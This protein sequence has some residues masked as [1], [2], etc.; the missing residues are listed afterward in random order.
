MP[1]DTKLEG[2]PESIRAVADWL[3]TSLQSNVE[4]AATQIFNARNAAGSG[5]SGS[6][7]EAFRQRMTRGGRKADDLA[8]GIDDMAQKFD[9]HA[10]KL[11]QAQEAMEGA[12]GIARSGG[13][14]IH[15]EV[16][17]DAGPAPAS[18]T[19]LPGD[20]SAT[21]EMVHART[22]AVDA[23]NSHARKVDAYRAATAEV[24][25][26]RSLQKVW[27]ETWVNVGNDL[28]EKWFFTVSDLASGAVETVLE[29]RASDLLKNSKRLADD[30]ANMIGHYLAAGDDV[31]RA[32][33]LSAADDA[34]KAADDLAR[35]STALSSKIAARMP[36]VGVV[37]T[38]GG[39]G[40]D[41][42]TGKPPAKAIVSGVGGMA[43]SI[44]TGALV[45]TA[46]GGPVGTVAGVVV[47]TAVGLVTSGAIDA[48]WDNAPEIGSAIADGAEAVGDAVGD[49]ASAVG[50]GIK[51]AWDA[52]F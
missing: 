20:G 22:A 25:H 27:N 21:P 49:A 14:E 26:A 51:D 13:L 38:A 11:Q 2:N 23:Q 3:R 35:Q 1:L 30:A 6:A 39:I 17:Q 44:A 5:W 42:A 45:G 47:G 9:E 52:V 15:G 33:A 40:H 24:D 28:K 43:A 18:A 37:L 16:I 29:A 34:L 48:V 36:V 41:I 8:S 19:P 7:S 50:G 32:A 12:R 31:T 10:A 46:I 4:S